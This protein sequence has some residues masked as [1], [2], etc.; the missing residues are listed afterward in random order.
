MKTPF[1][2]GKRT[3]LHDPKASVVASP[4]SDSQAATILYLLARW[5]QLPE[6]HS[7]FNHDGEFLRFLK[8]FGGVTLHI[9]EP[10]KVGRMFRNVKI[11]NSLRR[12][13][14]GEAFA[15]KVR[16]L[17][18]TFELSENRIRG[19]FREVDEEIRKQANAIDGLLK[20][21]GEAGS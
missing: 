9:P 17:A 21:G 3:F 6:L 2:K 10:D 11:W 8:E 18:Q 7:F 14:E 15:A 5:T 20:G 1:L 16:S 4:T 13:P 19:I 12:L